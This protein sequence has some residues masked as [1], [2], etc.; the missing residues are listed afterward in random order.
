LQG[1]KHFA[2]SSVGAPQDSVICCGTF[3]KRKTSAA[4]LCQ[5]LG[6][7]TIEIIVNSIPG[8]MILYPAS[9]HRPAWVDGFGF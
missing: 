4:E 5:I 9:V 6:M 3:P 1:T 2:V 7:V 8:G